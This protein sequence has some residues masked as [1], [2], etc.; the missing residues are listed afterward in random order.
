MT[1]AIAPTLPN[2]ASSWIKCAN[3]DLRSAIR[4]T[5]TDLPLVN[6]ANSGIPRIRESS[7]CVDGYG[8]RVAGGPPIRASGPMLI[9]ASE[10]ERRVDLGG[11]PAVR[12][13]G[14][15]PIPV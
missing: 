11:F 5:K 13:E 9:L 10:A 15:E 8:V 6:S 3:R 7:E 2:F 4:L 1:K 12:P 14:P